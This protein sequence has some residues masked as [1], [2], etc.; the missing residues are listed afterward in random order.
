M[1]TG[2]GNFRVSKT[3]LPFNATV[4]KSRRH[5][6]EYVFQS[7]KSPATGGAPIGNFPRGS[8]NSGYM[9]DRVAP[10]SLAIV[11]YFPDS[12]F[13]HNPIMKPYPPPTSTLARV[14]HTPYSRI[15]LRLPRHQQTPPDMFPLPVGSLP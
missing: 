13:A 4:T 12:S 11:R 8:V 10:S 1:S 2:A 7:E 3:I 9:I 15:G 5:S 6:I 14:S